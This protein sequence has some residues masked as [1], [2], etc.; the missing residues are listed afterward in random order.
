MD[1]LKEWALWYAEH[2]FAVIQL[3]QG[4]KIPFKGSSGSSDATR[5]R[6]TI[7]AWWTRHPSG[8]IGLVM[9]GKSGGVFAVDVDEK[10]SK[11][12]HGLASLKDWEKEH[13][14]LPDTVCSLSGSG[15]GGFH[16]LYRANPGERIRSHNDAL[17]HVDIRG[18]GTYILA[19]P[20]VHPDTGKKYEWKS[21]PVDS[22]IAHASKNVYD[23]THEQWRE[24]GEEMPFEDMGAPYELPK[25]IREGSRTENM[26]RLLAALQS[27]GL[28][29]DAIKAALR[30]ENQ[31]RCHPPLTD[32]ELA[33]QVFPALGRYAKGDY[34][35]AGGQDAP[36]APASLEVIPLETLEP[37][38]VKWLWWPYIPK[39]KLTVLLA[40]PGVGKT[41]LCLK[42]AAILSRGDAFFGEEG[43]G[44]RKPGTVIYQSAEDGLADTIVGR[45]RSMGAD[46]RNIFVI[47]EEKAALD[48]MDGRIEEA[49]Q[50][51]RP[52]LF[53]FDPLQ[54][55]LGAGLDMHRANEVRPV[56]AHLGFLAEKYGCSI[57]LIAHMS[58]MS[59]NEALYRV[60]GSIDIVAVARSLL[61]LVRNRE[62]EDSFYMAHDK[63]SL[64]RK[65][66]S[67]LFRIDYGN[68]GIVC[69]GSTDESADELMAKTKPKA[70]PALGEAVEFLKEQLKDGPADIKDIFSAAEDRGIKRSTLY[71]ARLEMKI[72][73][74]SKGFGTGKKT[75]WDL[76]VITDEGFLD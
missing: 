70:R 27:K 9:G 3:P 28:S 37:E 23:L 50:K 53:V 61:I 6:K 76:P 68:G 69:T 66:K 29:D 13:G 41:T 7:E 60:L 34:T 59:Q 31:V 46:M 38:K 47:S 32:A 43:V 52:G 45:L 58:K 18:E 39:G 24:G 30:E 26:F 11:G 73:S 10:P 48:F 63:S 56:L 71:D 1:T 54:A 12:K 42:L 55:Y 35:A 5:D 67:L 36:K 2:G 64:A 57:I 8:N 65:G 62:A 25:S 19:P 74:E 44:G 4:S 16:L 21:S 49:M 40:D 15:E 33:S 20:S 17:R 22:A 72:V 51:Y 75:T 14:E